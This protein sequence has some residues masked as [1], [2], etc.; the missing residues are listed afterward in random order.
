VRESRT[1]PESGLESGISI[2]R[3]VQ[4]AAFTIA[5]AYL[6]YKGSSE[7]PDS[8]E[9]VEAKLD[10]IIEHLGL[11]AEKIESQLPGKYQKTS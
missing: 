2:V 10:A 11:D 4:L 9:R 6:V 7:S 1:P 5:A 8:D 3:L